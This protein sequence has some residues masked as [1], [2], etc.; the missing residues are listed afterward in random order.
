M[1]RIKHD[2][3][4]FVNTRIWQVAHEIVEIAMKYDA[5]IAIEKL[6]NLRKRNGEGKSLR[7][8]TERYIE[9]SS[10][11]SSRLF[12]LWH[13]STALMSLKCRQQQDHRNAAPMRIHFEEELGFLQRKEKAV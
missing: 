9:F 11:S 2:E 1:R 10:T 4:N 8:P 3:R 13:G 7:K 5:M 6:K 12:N